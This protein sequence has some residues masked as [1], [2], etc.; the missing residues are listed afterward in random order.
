MHAMQMQ[1]FRAYSRKHCSSKHIRHLCNA[2]SAP[3]MNG[4]PS[5]A[6]GPGL[7]SS[8]TE[9]DCIGRA[10]AAGLSAK[11]KM[12]RRL[13][14]QFCGLFLLSPLSNFVQQGH[15]YKLQHLAILQSFLKQ[16]CKSPFPICA[17]WVVPG[18]PASDCRLLCFCVQEGWACKGLRLIHHTSAMATN[19]TSF[20]SIIPAQK[21]SV[22]THTNPMCQASA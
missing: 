17:S 1:A 22:H 8:P 14:T 19:I 5:T 18:A 6:R 10:A 20:L 13:A 11:S 12:A 21:N 16:C 4:T 7:V 3:P 15:Y 9:S 2:K